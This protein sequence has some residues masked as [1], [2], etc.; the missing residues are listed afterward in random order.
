MS[1]LPA[2]NPAAEPDITNAVFYPDISPTDCRNA[3]RL[4]QNITAERLRMALVEAIKFVNTQLNQWK[5]DQMAV[6]IGVLEEV[7]ADQIDGESEHVSSYRSAVYYL[8]KADLLEQ[9]RDYDTT[10]TGSQRAEEKDETA[11]DYRRKGL[12][13]INNIQA[14]PH[15]IVE[16][17]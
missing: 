17:I 6:G 11:D 8:A 9:Y 15:T 16:L 4:E 1:F 13:A 10:A 7:N 14:R 5:L 12:L 3:V 2:Q